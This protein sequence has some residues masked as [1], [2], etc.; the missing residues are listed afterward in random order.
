MIRS[1][2]RARTVLVFVRQVLTVSGC[3]RILVRGRAVFVVFG[4]LY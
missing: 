2:V 1:R 4:V 3:G